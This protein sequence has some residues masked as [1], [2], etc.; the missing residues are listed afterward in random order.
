MHVQSIQANQTTNN[1]RKPCF[2]A[3][4]VYDNAGYFRRLWED[5][6][7]DTA[8]KQKIDEFVCKHENHKLEITGK[9][10][11]WSRINSNTLDEETVPGTFYDIFNR[12]TGKFTQ[13][14]AAG[15]NR[16]NLF[17][18]LCRIENDEGIFE[19]NFITEAYQSLTGQEKPVEKITITDDG[20]LITEK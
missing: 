20:K 12:Y 7:K 4:F 6:R 8:L 3:Q 11:G 18:L 15:P 5:A 13:Y 1:C 2:K 10:D 19:N 17:N 14:F 16:N 9:R